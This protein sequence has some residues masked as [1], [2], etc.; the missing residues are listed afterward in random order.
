MSGNLPYPPPWMDGATLA[1]HI[2]VSS[3]TIDNWVAQGILP[4]PRKRGGKLM[5]KWQEV[6]ERLTLGTEGQ[7]ETLAERIRNG[8]RAEAAQ[9][10]PRH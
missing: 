3:T 6:D 10:N 2:C 7:P 9:T 5:W 4:P 8:T 1:R